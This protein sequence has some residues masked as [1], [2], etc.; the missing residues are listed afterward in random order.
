M[1][2]QLFAYL[3]ACAIATAP[4]AVMAQKTEPIFEISAG[5]MVADAKF[6]IQASTGQLITAN[7]LKLMAIDPVKKAIIWETGKFIGLDESDVDVIDGTPFIKIERK[8]LLSISN[9]K[10][11][12]IINATDGAVVYDSKDEGIKVRNSLIIPKA[13]G[14][15]LEVVKDGFLS[16]TFIDINTAKELWTVPLAKEKSGGIGLKALKR[17]VKTYSNSAFNVPPI[18]DAAGNLILVNKKE[19]FAISKAGTLAWKKE[20]NKDVTDAYLGQDDKSIFIGYNDYI[21]KLNTATGTSFLKKPIEMRD[22]LNGIE[23]LG[24]SYIV[25]NEKGVN[26]MDANGNMKWKKDTKLGNVTTVKYNA[27]G[28]LAIIEDKDDTEFIWL[29]MDG[30]DKWNEKIKGAY[31]L[32][33][34][35]EKGIMYVTTERSNILTYEKGKDVWNKD[36]K[37]KGMP[38][39]G[40]DNVNSILYAF[41]K[42]KLHSFNF[43]DFSYKLIAEDIELKKWDEDK[44]PLNIDVRNSGKNVMLYTNQ[45]VI[46]ITTADG[47]QVY[48]NYFKDIG[49]SRKKLMRFAGAALSIAGS[50]KNISEISKGNITASQTVDAKGNAVANST[51]ISA[52]SQAGNNIAN[53]GDGMYQAAKQRFLASQATKDNLYILSEMPEGNG[54]L[55]WN[56]DG[57]KA[58][59]KITFNDI[60][61]KF[62]VDE[63]ADVVYVIVG[64]TIKAYNLK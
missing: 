59:K 4:I 20:Y 19:V 35:T 37:L 21:D 56:K 9:S 51:T 40:Y 7:P 26:I 55:V 22:A 41:A 48:N 39:F 36:I 16:V 24:D 5:N 6:L 12:Y 50:A 46:N 60:T 10:N 3:I 31:T 54:M 64:N 30:K 33:E 8:K 23:P 2:K 15:L 27:N 11:T 25:Y 28:I 62:V 58:S 52:S 17:A 45:N 44:E 1:T 18:V 47:K 13:A 32:A 63:A 53:A 43:A 49:S 34:L 38:F 61:P 14:L 57:G 42:D 29:T